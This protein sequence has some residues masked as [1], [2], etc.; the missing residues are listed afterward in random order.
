MAEKREEREAVRKRG[1][2][3]GEGREARAKRGIAVEAQGR[4]RRGGRQRS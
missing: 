3:A 4:K 1:A 2:G